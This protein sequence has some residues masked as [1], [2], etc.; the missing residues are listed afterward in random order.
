MVG[1][2]QVQPETGPDVVDDQHDAP[3]GAELA[4][5]RPVFL[6]RTAVV[7]EIAV[8]I[9]LGD[10]RRHIPL[11]RVISRFQGRNVE[12]G[13]DDVVGHFLRQD[14]GVVGLHGPGLVA[15]VIAPEEDGL[16]LSGGRPG[17]QVCESGGIGAVLHEECP[18]GASHGIHQQFG[19]LHHFVGGRGG[20]V[21][22]HQLLHG[23]AVHVRVTVAQDIGAVGAHQVQ[24]LV[25]VHVPEV[26][27]LGLGRDQRPLLQRQEQSLAG[28]QV[29]VNAGGN[30]IQ[31]PVEPGAALFMAVFG[32]FTHQLPLLTQ[33]RP[34]PGPGYGSHCPAWRSC[35]A[36][37]WCP[38]TSR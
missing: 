1:A 25:A 18:V 13:T 33:D 22:H 34:R 15:V 26:G 6:G 8:V 23:G 32:I 35:P 7:E 19:A 31:R 12:P 30:H 21:T 14:A 2:G 17:G 27:T 29:A 4:Y 11:G 36:G 37:R 16:L 24:I 3:L 28:A 10:Q 9:G 20:A 38:Y 5:L